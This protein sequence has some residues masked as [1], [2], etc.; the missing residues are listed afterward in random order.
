MKDFFTKH[1]YGFLFIIPGVILGYLYWKYIGCVSGTCA[2]KSNWHTMILFGGLIGYF[3]GD[4]V[5]D[6][7]VKRKKKKIKSENQAE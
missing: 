1:K 6:F 7:I 3:V 2:I 4:S 5:D